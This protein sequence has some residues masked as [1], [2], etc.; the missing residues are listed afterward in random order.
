M[1]SITFGPLMLI[2]NKIDSP[3][4]G[5]KAEEM[6]NE[7]SIKVEIT[8]SGLKYRGYMKIVLIWMEICL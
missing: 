3:F 1:Y 6:K 8:K 4:S 2:L 7:I 5:I